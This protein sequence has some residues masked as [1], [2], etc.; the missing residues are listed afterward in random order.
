MD[1]LNIIHSYGINDEYYNVHRFWYD[2][3]MFC[4]QFPTSYA[5]QGLN[6][7]SKN[8]NGSRDKVKA[9]PIFNGLVPVT[10]KNNQEQ[11]VYL[12]IYYFSP[13][14]G[15]FDSFCSEIINDIDQ[16]NTSGRILKCTAIY[17][18]EWKFNL[19]KMTKVQSDNLK[20]YNKINYI[21]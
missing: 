5:V 15:N 18:L 9:H 4:E 8:E 2:H 12:D 16:T 11:P 10:A 17:P 6:R 3:W 13:S 1:K 19:N 21:E 14:V 20:K 7:P